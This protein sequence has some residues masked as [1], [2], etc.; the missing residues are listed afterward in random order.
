MNGYGPTECSDDVTH[1]IIDAPPTEAALL[2]PVG[3]TVPNLELYV[4]DRDLHVVPPGIPGELYVGGIGVGRGY[5]N[6]PVTTAEAFV[7]HPFQQKPGRRLYK[8]GDRVRVGRNGTF[9]FLG[10][11]DHQVK[12]RGFRIELGEIEAHLYK[13]SAIQEA[14]VIVREDESSDKRLA[15]YIIRVVGADLNSNQVRS[16]MREQ[17]PEYMVPSAF[18]FLERFPLTLN[19]KIDIRALP[20]PEQSVESVP[21]TAPRNAVES[22]LVDIWKSVLHRSEIGVHDNFF[23]LGGD[24][25]LSIKI[26]ARLNDIGLKL[27]TREI[28]Q[29]QTI[30]ELASVVAQAPAFSAEQG[31]ITGLVPLTPVQRFFFEELDLPNRHHYNQAV[32]LEMR[33]KVNLPRL[34]FALSQLLM[35][36]DMLRARFVQKGDTW[37]CWIAGYDGDMPFVYEDLSLLE[38]ETQRTALEARA[39]ELQASLNISDGPVI[40]IAY[41]ECGPQQSACLLIV[42]HHLVIDTVS[43]QILLEDLER[44][45]RQVSAGKAVY[46]PPRTTSFKSWAEQLVLHAQTEALKQEQSYWLDLPWKQVRPLP[47]DYPEAS[48]S[49]DAL[50]VISTSL[51]RAETQVL[52]QQV[53]KIYHCQMND[54]L[55][56]ALAE[57]FMRWIGDTALLLDF[58]GHGREEM[59]DD[60][61]LSRTVGWFTSVAP[62]VLQLPAQRTTAQAIQSVKQQRQR[63]PNGGIGF[64]LLRYL[65][66]EHSGFATLPRSQVSFNYLGQMTADNTQGALFGSVLENAG[67]PVAKGG[68]LSYLIDVECMVQNEIVHIHWVYSEAV[69]KRETIEQI[70]QWYVD[71]LRSIVAESVSAEVQ[72]DTSYDTSLIDVNNQTL[73]E[74]LLTVRFD[75]EQ[76]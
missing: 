4:L 28:F 63:M 19:G 16:W 41:F 64:G 14:V 13:H 51:S 10:R 62:L 25:I 74:L 32:L 7:P 37:E 43:W 39:S 70:S 40:R 33:E 2:V 8:T 50:Y 17:I 29:Y 6:D 23:E 34:Q 75:D 15:A 69:Y 65:S 20:A 26:I 44:V 11:I 54:A 42:A 49:R 45:Y 56:T 73:S 36:H 1:H 9:E 48:N 38:G 35:H 30:A 67:A 71:A 58:E 59:F 27:T 72:Q 21:G 66:P 24:S 3:Q 61:S 46:L 57:T 5:L 52:L 68:T 22:M 18:V 47:K 55:L 12:V 60:L 53:P 76:S 31:E